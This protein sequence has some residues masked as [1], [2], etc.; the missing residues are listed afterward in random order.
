[1]ADNRAIRAQNRHWFILIVFQI[2]RGRGAAI[3]AARTGTQSL[4]RTSRAQWPSQP[5]PA[6][7]DRGPYPPTIVGGDGSRTAS[8][9]KRHPR[10]TARQVN[11]PASRLPVEKHN[12]R[13]CSICRRSSWDRQ[14]SVGQLLGNRYPDAA[15]AARE[16]GARISQRLSHCLNRFGRNRF[17]QLEPST[18]HPAY[19]RGGSEIM[20]RPLQRGAR[21]S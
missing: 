13:P 8:M 20:Q 15:S 16:V 7:A 12:P 6:P 9:K 4:R 5:R 21:H 17:S 18:G 19:R 11:K 14:Y 1:M 3:T 2:P 10:R